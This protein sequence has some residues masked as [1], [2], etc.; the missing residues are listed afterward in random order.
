[1][2]QVA[3][4]RVGEQHGD[5]HVR[6]EVLDGGGH[7]V[8]HVGQRG[9]PGDLLE[10]RAVLGGEPLRV[11]DLGGFDADDADAGHRAGWRPGGVRR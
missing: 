10:E 4:V 6:R 7:A 8:E 1:M 5:E 3:A 2:T 9:L 11:L